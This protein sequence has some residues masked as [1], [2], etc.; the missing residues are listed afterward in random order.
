MALGGDQGGSIRMPASWSGIVGHK[1]TWGLVPYTGAFPIELTLDHLGPMCRSVRD[2]ARMLEVIAG[3]DGLDPRQ[4]GAVTQPYVRGPRARRGGP[5]R[6]HPD[7][8]LR[9]AGRVRARRRRGRAR[10]RAD[11]RVARRD[12]RRG[13][14]PDPPRRPRDLDRDRRRGRDRADGQGQRHG[15][16]PQGHYT[17][18][19]SDFFGGARRSAPQDFSP[20]VKLTMLV[21]EYMAQRYDR[22]YYAKGQN[23][24]RRLR[25]AY[26]AALERFDVLVMPT[27]AMKALPL[28]RADASVTEIVASALANLAQHR[29]VRRDRP[30]GDERAVRPLG[31]PAGRHD[32]RRPALRR[33]DGAARG[34]RLR[35]GA[36]RARAGARAAAAA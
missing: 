27:T 33:R 28:P 21:G 18:D 35:D 4:G 13:V 11:L 26:D 16:E 9:L 24:S 10:G 6:R 2:C 12:G 19:L 17:T 30:P 15:H 20:T 34:P 29:R 5:A 14:G 22:H 1:P 3:P 8:G 36:R 32:A 7:R 31:R 23:L 25:A